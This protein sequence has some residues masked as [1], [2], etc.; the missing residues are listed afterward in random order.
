M[1]DD[2]SRDTVAPKIPPRLSR[3]AIPTPIATSPLSNGNGNTI[4]RTKYV[5]NRFT[6]IDDI[7][8]NIHDEVSAMK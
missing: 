4:D 5:K 6:E 2:S 3:H 1:D 8:N 7:L